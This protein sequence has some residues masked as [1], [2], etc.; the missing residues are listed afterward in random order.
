MRDVILKLLFIQVN[1]ACSNKMRVWIVLL[2]CVITSTTA[3]PRQFSHRDFSALFTATLDQ[4]LDKPGISGLAQ[5][6]PEFTFFKRYMQFRDE[7]I[8]HATDDAIR[9]FN[10]SYGLDFSSSAPNVQNERFFENARMHPFIIPPDI[11]NYLVTSNN[12]IRSG[13][14]RS[15]SYLMRVGGFLVNFSADQTLRGSYGGTEGKPAGPAV[16]LNYGFYNIDVCPQSPVIIQVQSGSPFRLEPVDGHYILNFE[17]YST[18]LGHGAV[19]GII[20]STQISEN[21]SLYHVIIR[22]TI[23]F[24]EPES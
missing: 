4:T 10:E 23:T 19:Q 1:T 8:Q 24:P 11:I 20:S 9:F 6:D 15:V 18:V 21:P 13:S 7:A 22:S 14:T 2:L 16:F 5:A 17:L 12:W 3:D